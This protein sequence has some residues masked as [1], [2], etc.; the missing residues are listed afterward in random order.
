MKRMLCALALAAV[1]AAALLPTQAMAQVG[2]N[3][4]IGTPPPPRYERM[5]PP[6]VG[7]LWAPGY[8]NWDGRR[9][10][11]AG[12]HWERARNGYRY[13]RPQWQHGRNGWELHRGGW[14]HG[15]GHGG[16]HDQRRDHH[17]GNDHR[18]R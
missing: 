4:I 5:P 10:V 14:Q 7:Y 17:R 15:G 1:S 8:W 12:G 18:Y 2:V 6:R 3:I 11:W 16:R 13:D 9:H